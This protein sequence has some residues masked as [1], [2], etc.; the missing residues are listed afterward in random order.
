MALFIRGGMLLTMTARGVFQGDV[1]VSDGRILAVAEQLPAS[2]DPDAGQVNAAGLY[3]LPG[4]IDAH[5]HYHAEELPVLI[6]AARRGGLAA[7]LAWPDN[8]SRCLLWQGEEQVESP[9]LPVSMAESTDAELARRLREAE[10]AGLRPALE[11]RSRPQAKRALSAVEASGVRAILLHLT[12]CLPM[13]EAIA[14]SGCPVVVGASIRGTD[15]P[16]ALAARLDELG[17]TVAVTSDHPKG[18]LHHLPLCAGLCV[19]S[20]MPWERALRTITANPAVLLGLTDAGCIA[21][22]YRSCLTLYDGD[23]L[24]LSTSRVLTLSPR[25]GRET[26]RKLQCIGI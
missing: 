19:R 15:N 10:D 24:L 9:V 14:A 17:V 16:F 7:V 12:D 5:A 6:S 1:L 25:P 26:E 3:V 20:G 13:A 22:G 21:P 8:A 4:L 23:P 18:Q 2:L 11:V